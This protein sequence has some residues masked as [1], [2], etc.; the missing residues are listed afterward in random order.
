MVIPVQLRH[1]RKAGYAGYSVRVTYRRLVPLEATGQTITVLDETTAFV[2]AD[3]RG[4]VTLPER[5]AISDDQPLRFAVVAPDGEVVREQP[6]AAGDLDPDEGL[7]IEVP[8]KAVLP[9]SHRDDPLFGKPERA[10]GMLVD[11]AGGGSRLE[12]VK[13]AIHGRRRGA[14]E[15]SRET[16]GVTVTDRN[17]YFSIAYPAVLLE[18]AFG[19][20]ADQFDL[21]LPVTLEDDGTFPARMVLGLERPIP[22][23]EDDCACDTAVPRGPDQVDLTTSPGTF[24]ED[25]GGGHCVDMTKPN[26]VLEEFSYH[27]VVRTTEPTIRGMQLGG[28]GR[29]AVKDVLKVTA[30]AMYRTSAASADLPD[31]AGAVTTRSDVRTRSSQSSP[32]RKIMAADAGNL[33]ALSDRMLSVDVS[34]L[35]DDPDLD[36]AL[37]AAEIDVDI[38]RTLAEDPDGFTLTKLAHAEVLTKVKDLGTL[39]AVLAKRWPGRGVLTCANEVDWDHTPTIYQACTIAHGHIL[40]LKQEW[41]ADG[42]SLG[43]LLY[44]LPLAPCQKKQ[45]AVLDWDRSEA[46][47]RTEMLEA[48][49]SLE[50]MLARDRDISEVVNASL[51][52]SIRAGSESETDSHSAGLGHGGGVGLDFGLLSFGAGLS[53]GV[54]FGGGSASTSAWQKASRDTAASSLQQLRDR[55]TQSASAVRSQRSTVIQSVRQGETVTAQ[56]EV[57]ANHNHCH[58]ITVQ[59]FE[60]LRHFLVRQRLTS[61]QECLF[62]PLLMSRFDSAKALR[63]RQLLLRGL[64]NRRLRKGFDALQRIRDSY[65]GSDLPTGAYAEEEIVF[66]EGYVK[67][68]MRITRPRDDDGD[69]DDAAWSPLGLFLGITGQSWWE[70]HLEQQKERDRIFEERLAPKIAEEIVDRLR[71]YAVDQ[72]DNETELPIDASLVTDFKND[73]ELY[74]SLRQSGALPPIRRDAVKAIRIAAP[75]DPPLSSGNVFVQAVADALTPSSRVLVTSGRMHYRTR[76]LSHDLFRNSHILNDL[77]STDDVRVYTP[78]SA[79]ELR[80]PR[81]ED[82]ELSRE[83]L[84]QLNDHIEYYHRAIWWRMDAQRRFLLLDGFIAPNSGGRSV[85]SVVENRLIGIVGNCLVMPVAPGVHLDPTFAQDVEDP[86]DLL[87]H[88]Q[89][90]TPVEPFRLALPTRGVFAESVMGSCNSCE[91]KDESRFWRWEESPCPDDPT[92]IAPVSTES[93]RAEP[94]DLTAKDFPSPIIAMQTAPAAPD[95]TGLSSAL[96]LL[97]KAGIF[98]NLAGVEGTQRNALE[99]LKR[100]YDSSEFFAAQAAQLSGRGGDI[101]L[102]GRMGRDIDK[103]V[104]KIKAAKAEGLITGES[105]GKLIEQALQAMIGGGAGPKAD[106]MTTKDV[107]D[108]T[109]AAGKNDASVSLRRPSGERVDVDASDGTLEDASSPVIDLTPDGRQPATRAFFP[110]TAVGKSG[111]ISLKAI[112]RNPP[113]GASVEWH[114][115]DADAI[116]IQSPSSMQ[117]KV[118]AKRPGTTDMTFALKN[119]QGTRIGSFRIPLS[120][121]QFVTVDED[122]TAFD[123][124]LADLQM[125]DVKSA[126]LDVAKATC[127]HLLATSNVRTV[128]VVNLGESVPSHV[129]ANRITRVTIRN[130]SAAPSPYGSTGLPAGPTEFDEEID[131]FPGAY[132]NPSAIDVTPATQTLV[133]RLAS[134]DFTDPVLKQLGIDVF[135]RLL[136]ETMAHEIIHSLL[137]FLIPTGH[138]DPPIANDLMNRGVDRDFRQRTGIEVT[139]TA[140]FPAPGSFTDHGIAAI[141]GLQAANQGRVDGVYPI[142]ADPI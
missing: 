112:V 70:Q 68:K 78:L 45:I 106:P 20:V 23:S 127:D 119:A 27:R 13:V 46:A 53:G 69:F 111:V 74:I 90:T 49:E 137:A 73:R 29:I 26:R 40:E 100:A 99:A 110:N 25:L 71:F 129:P 128:W 67:M 41:I 123:Q 59:Y 31:V 7:T 51:R 33:S 34:D 21:P 3:G 141:G 109:E 135:G 80:R 28:R 103:A 94:P 72:Y 62:I 15:G 10:R 86:V 64:R 104:E 85:A 101:A 77:S 37:E 107:K 122:Q 1:D 115:L 4:E 57:V 42:Y 131:L 24:T 58:A 98:E 47:A 54:S 16:L 76:H 125:G 142:A 30:S 55:V 60:V 87:E 6:V 38:A 138:N 88:Y 61:V 118:L 117:T 81:E 35:A 121:P 2:E 130:E 44:S 66:L 19:V 113:S 134:Q 39:L 9:V 124:A 102:Q 14:P 108:L 48:R 132:D 140:S 22:R 83:L 97:G 116:E 120:V 95:P 56:T 84:R 89:P 36:A 8:P 79:A 43:D 32:L 82:K 91:R 50:A 12:G 105:A 11:P 63:W 96:S 139:D 65:V 114:T 92:P 17:G 75:V 52:E 126:L 133:Q 18:E 93:R 136:G 5:D